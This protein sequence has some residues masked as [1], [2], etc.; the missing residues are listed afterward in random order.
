MRLEL[1]QLLSVAHD[2]VLKEVRSGESAAS[3]G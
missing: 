1:L 2:E 3:R